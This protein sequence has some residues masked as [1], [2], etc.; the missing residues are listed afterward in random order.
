MAEVRK[1]T[2]GRGGHI[3]EAVAKAIGESVRPIAP[4]GSP[5]PSTTPVPVP[6][7]PETPITASSFLLSDPFLVFPEESESDEAAES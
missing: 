5:D 2:P 4:G 7:A 3:A 1:V 6:S